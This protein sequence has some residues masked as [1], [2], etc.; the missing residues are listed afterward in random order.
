MMKELLSLTDCLGIDL[1]KVT[2]L[3]AHFIPRVLC[4]PDI[5]FKLVAN[6]MLAIDPNVRTSMWWDL[7]QG[8]GTEIDYLNGAILKASTSLNLPCPVNEKIVQLVKSIS[9]KEQDALPRP[10]G[11]KELLRLVEQG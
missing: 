11:A 7:S 6:K 1:P 9:A 8:K 10:I 3:P 5:L 2:A 4:L